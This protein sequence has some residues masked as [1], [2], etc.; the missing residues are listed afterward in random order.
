MIVVVIPA[1]LVVVEATAV[2]VMVRLTP[3]CSTATASTPGAAPATASRGSLLAVP[4]E[5]FAAQPLELEAVLGGVGVHLVEG[6]EGAIVH[7]GNPVV[8]LVLALGLRC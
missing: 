1:I 2:V 3:E 4:H 5:A 7:L 8:A 6:T